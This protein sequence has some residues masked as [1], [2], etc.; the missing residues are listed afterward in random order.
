VSAEENTRL[1]QSAYEAFGRGDMPALAELMADDIEWVNP[2]DP[3]DDPMA[4]TYRGKDAVLGWFGKLAEHLDFS[5][6][7]PRDFIAQGDKVVSIVYAEATVRSTGRSVVQDEAHVWTFSDG[8]LARFQ[9][10]FDT[11]AA[12]AAHRAE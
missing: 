4:G 5:T 6:F 7:E 3:D 1:A 2:G 9:I 12:A 8:K 10:Y 11:A